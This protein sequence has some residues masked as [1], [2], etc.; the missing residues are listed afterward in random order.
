MTEACKKAGLTTKTFYRLYDS[1]ERF[2]KEVDEAKR[3][4][5]LFNCDY[6]VTAGKKKISE[7][8]WPAI[9]HFLDHHVTPYKEDKAVNSNLLDEIRELKLELLK[10][11]PI[12]ESHKDLMIQALKAQGL[13]RE[14]PERD[15]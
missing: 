8:H 15:E 11:Q 9:K 4:G 14:P 1:N 10:H 12:S 3:F 7:G 6:V 5:I 13:I 2:R